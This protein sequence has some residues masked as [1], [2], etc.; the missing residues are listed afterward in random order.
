MTKNEKVDKVVERVEVKLKQPHTQN[1]T[2]HPVG[3]VIEVRPD[4]RDRMV[5]E[6]RA[7]AV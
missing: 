5:K 7:V 1:R 6:N 3:A 4:Q 2:E